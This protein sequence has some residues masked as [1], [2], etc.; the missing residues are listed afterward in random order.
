[1]NHKVFLVCVSVVAGALALQAADWPRF[2][3][4]QAT[5]VSAE[6]GIAKNWNETQPP[7]LWRTAL[8]DDGYAGPAVA[9]GR[10]III[11]RRGEGDVVRA[12]DLNSGEKVWEFAYEEPGRSNYGFARSTPTIDGDHVY[13]LS[14][15]GV[16]HCLRFDDGSKVWSRD[17]IGDFDGR[18]PRWLMAMSPL[19]DGDRVIVQPGGDNAAVVALN[20]RTGETIWQGGG[21]DVGGY[22]TPVLAE[23]A[24][25]RQYVIFT[26][27]NVMGLDVDSGQ[28]LWRHEW[29]TNH[30]CNAATPLVMGQ[31]V[32]ITSGYRRG[33][34][35]IRVGEGAP[36][37]VWENTEIQS[38]FSTPVLHGAHVYSTT[39]PG[40]LV[41]LDPRTG[42]SVWRERGFEKGGLVLVDGVLIVVDG[43]NGQV[44]MVEATPE[45]YHELGRFD[46]LGGQS[47]TA[48]IIADG[49]L[50]IRNKGTLAVYNLKP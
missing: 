40:F 33:G 43:R 24:G 18:K 19:V 3:G 11:D 2:L 6:T 26:G 1:M 42:E 27:F 25:K 47:W 21:S 12:L 41:C 10:L 44:A 8:S 5:G 7:E 31:H 48:P 34:S 23:I 39:D 38:H 37:K 36:Q 28:Q 16:L 29:R 35:V 45:R 15:N 46:G 17:I 14:R 13:T 50:V 20:K 4:P 49:K 32:F 22:A 30:D 9:R